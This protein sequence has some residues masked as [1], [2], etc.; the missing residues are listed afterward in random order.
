[1][2]HASLPICGAWLLTLT[3]PDYLW[4]VS[5]SLHLSRSLSLT[6]VSVSIPPLSFLTLFGNRCVCYRQT[7]GS[8][9]P[10]S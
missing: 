4:Y 9:A 2:V 3:L 10:T 6:H 1:M 8:S 5:A 7:L